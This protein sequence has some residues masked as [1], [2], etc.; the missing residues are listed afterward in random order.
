LSSRMTTTTLGDGTQVYCLKPGE[1]KVLDSHIEGYMNHGIRVQPGDTVFDVGANIGMFG[2]RMAQRCNGDIR[3]I[4]FEPIPDI[5]ACT[6]KN[7]EPWPNAEVLPYG[8][9]SEP[10]QAT[11]TFFPNAPSLSTSRDEDWDHQEGAFEE[12]VA[13][14]T[15][16]APMW[17]ARLLPRFVAGPIAR[18]LR[19]DTVEVRCELVTLSQVISDHQVEQVDLLKIDCEG[20]EEEALLGLTEDDWSRVKQAVIEVHDIDGRL[21]RIEALLRDHGLTELTIE[22]E[23]ALEKTLLSNIYA[24]RPRD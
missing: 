20:A 13:G 10:G 18:W 12:A 24:Y 4:A 16:L 19:R 6:F 1:A 17:Y 21:D 9:A 22:K 2:M 3:V 5:R 8:V 7:L 14:N 15:K 11:F 23:E